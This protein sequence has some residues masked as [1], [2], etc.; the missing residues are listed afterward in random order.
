[1]CSLFTQSIRNCRATHH[2]IFIFYPNSLFLLMLFFS[3]SLLTLSMADSL[4]AASRAQTARYLALNYAPNFIFY[5]NLLFLLMLLFSI[6]LLT[7][8]VADSLGAASRAQTARY[9]ALNCDN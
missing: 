8:S 3:I 2:Q 1:M 6:S 4:G 9:L 7:L 5:P